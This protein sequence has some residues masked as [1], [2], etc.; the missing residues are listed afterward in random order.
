MTHRLPP[1]VCLLP[2]KIKKIFLGVAM[3]TQDCNGGSSV[4]VLGTCARAFM[5]S[6]LSSEELTTWA[7]L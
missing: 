7:H 3:A 2:K 5:N 4:V 6:D 1:M